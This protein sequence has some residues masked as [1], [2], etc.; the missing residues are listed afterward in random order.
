LKPT[1]PTLVYAVGGIVGLTLRLSPEALAA[2]G[3]DPSLPTALRTQFHALAEFR[4]QIDIS[5]AAQVEESE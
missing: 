5:F 1:D 3:N 4:E 2:A